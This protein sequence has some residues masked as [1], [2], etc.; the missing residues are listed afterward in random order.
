MAERLWTMKILAGVHAGAEVTL[1]DEEVILGRDD[2]CDFVFEDAGLAGR[3]ISLRAGTA[4]VRMTVLDGSGPVRVDGRPVEGS[5][6]LDPYQIVTVGGLSLALGPADQAWPPIDLPASPTPESPVAPDEADTGEDP[7]GGPIEESPTTEDSSEADT[8]ESGETSGEAGRSSSSRALVAGIVAA[9]LLA[10]AVAAWLLVPTQVRPEHEDPEEATREIR[11][12]A[13]RYGAVVHI[14]ADAGADGS[15]KVTGNIDT[16]QNLQHLL[17]ELAKVHVHATVQIRSTEEFAASVTSILNQSLNIDKHNEVTVQ[18]VEN[19]PGELT[20]SGYV[21]QDSS[22]SEARALLEHDVKGY[23]ALH[24][25]VQTMAD[26]VA[27]LR[28]RIDDLNLST[29]LHIQRLPEGVGLFGPVGKAEELA[30]IE[31]MVNGFN[32]EFGSRPTLALSGSDTFLGESTIDLDVRAVVL[33]DS[34]HVVLH[35]GESYRV[36]SRVLDHYVVKAIT[37]RYMVLEKARHL[38]G[39]ADHP[40]PDIAYFIFD[41]E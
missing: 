35:D 6:E 18:P 37:E 2:A 19:S 33:G 5:I 22:L 24:Y 23:V 8:G 11:E 38:S 32:D 17:D 16:T 31:E 29:S 36:G 40:G 14:E 15:L 9:V 20:L 28:R 27:I 41:D 30:R 10:V 39:D 25:D 13:S 34:V 21:E 12:L 1:S 7:T 26:R 4:D 3:H